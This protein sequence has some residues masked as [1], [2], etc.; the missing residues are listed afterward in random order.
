[1]A[2]VRTP[3]ALLI[4]SLLLPGAAGCSPQRRPTTLKV[5][6]TVALAAATYA[7]A[8]TPSC[9]SPEPD[10][11]DTFG[12]GAGLGAGLCAMSQ[13]SH[14][15]TGIGL[16][17][18]GALSLG[19]GLYLGRMRD[20]PRSTWPPLRS[21]EPPGRTRPAALDAPAAPLAEDPDVEPRVVQLARTAWMA[22]RL[23]RCADARANMHRIRNADAR[24]YYT[25]IV[26]NPTMAAC[27]PPVD[28]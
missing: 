12:I 28:S 24:Y 15:V 18:P 3:T 19:A 6:G 22:A 21:T 26:P 23:G 10:P 17:L 25:F 5:V 27:A 13:A 2:R 1:V 16:G 8:T 7:L 4:T 20:E 9:P 14:V 11:D